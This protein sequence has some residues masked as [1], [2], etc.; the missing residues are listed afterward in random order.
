MASS[1]PTSRWSSR[2]VL[3]ATASLA[4]AGPAP[5]KAE[6]PVTAPTET[7]AAS[8]SSDYPTIDPSLLDPGVVDN[9]AAQKR[10]IDEAARHVAI[11]GPYFDSYGLTTEAASAFTRARNTGD[12][13]GARDGQSA[14][15]WWRDAEPKLK[16]LMVEYK[17]EQQLPLQIAGGIVGGAG[18]LMA[19]GAALGAYRRRKTPPAP[20]GRE[21]LNYVLGMGGP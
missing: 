16:E 11:A 10:I 21:R 5:A 6:A 13:P 20:T 4:L 9:P 15:D 7:A 1:S 17:A 8:V 18:L 12:F 14:A 19:G 3:A 2:L